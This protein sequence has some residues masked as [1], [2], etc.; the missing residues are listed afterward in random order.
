MN[1]GDHLVIAVV[2][3]I[4]LALMELIALIGCM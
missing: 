1:A 4:F 2:S 3:P